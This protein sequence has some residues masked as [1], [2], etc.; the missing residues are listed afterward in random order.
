M[1]FP[2]PL[3]FIKGFGMVVG[4]FRCFSWDFLGLFLGFLVGLY[5]YTLRASRSLSCVLRD[6]LPSF[7]DK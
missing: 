6:V 4:F 3:K 5:M 1:R 2:F 7:L